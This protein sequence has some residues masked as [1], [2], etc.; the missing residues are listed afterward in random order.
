MGLVLFGEGSEF[1]SDIVDEVL[2][3]TSGDLEATLADGFSDAGTS[4]VTLFGSKEDAGSSAYSSATEECEENAG[5][6]HSVE[7]CFVEG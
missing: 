1:L 6:S 5:T 4:F 3:F 2:E 7:M